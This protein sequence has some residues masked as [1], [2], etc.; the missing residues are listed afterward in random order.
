MPLTALPIS[1]LRGSDP[2]PA[3]LWF[4]SAWQISSVEARHARLRSVLYFPALVAQRHNPIL[5]VFAERLRAAGKPKLAVIAAVMRKL[6]HLIY[7]ILKS[8]QPFDPNFL[9]QPAKPLDFQD[10]IYSAHVSNVSTIYNL[11]TDF[12]DRHIIVS[13]NRFIKTNFSKLTLLQIEVSA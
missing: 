12:R 7:G 2:A 8:G 13:C 6:L 3:H 10:G 5:R 1:R 4:V 9:A 11:F